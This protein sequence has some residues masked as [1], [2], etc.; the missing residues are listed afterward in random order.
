MSVLLLFSQRWSSHIGWSSLNHLGRALEPS[1]KRKQQKLPGALKVHR[2]QCVFTSS[3]FL[4]VRNQQLCPVPHRSPEKKSC[5]DCIWSLG[6]ISNKSYL[7]K[8]GCSKWRHHMTGE[9][10]DP[11]HWSTVSPRPPPPPQG[12]KKYIFLT[13]LIDR[14]SSHLVLISQHWTHQFL[15]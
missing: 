12:I 5:L 8:T 15:R 11:S 13:S 14:V 2:E 6:I 7:Q 1:S 4:M 3:L 10:S 9:Q